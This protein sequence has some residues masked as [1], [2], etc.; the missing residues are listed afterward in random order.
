MNALQI[1]S[2][3]VVL[4]LLWTGGS[5]ADDPSADGAFAGGRWTD[6]SP[7]TSHSAATSSMSRALRKN[8]GT[9]FF[10]DRGPKLAVV[11]SADQRNGQVRVQVVRA[12]GDKSTC[13]V[14]GVVVYM[15]EASLGDLMLSETVASVAE[16]KRDGVTL[17]FPMKGEYSIY[18]YGL[19][20]HSQKRTKTSKSLKVISNKKGPLRLY[21]VKVKVKYRGMA[22]Q[23]TSS[24]DTRVCDAMWMMENSFVGCNQTMIKSTNMVVAEA[25][26]FQQSQADSLISKTK[27]QWTSGFGKEKMSI[28]EEYIIVHPPYHQQPWYPGLFLKDLIYSLHYVVHYTDYDVGQP[29]VWG[30]EVYYQYPGYPNYPVLYTPG[31]TRDCDVDYITFWYGYIDKSDVYVQT[32]KSTYLLPSLAAL[33]Y[34]GKAYVYAHGNCKGN[35]NITA[36]SNTWYFEIIHSYWR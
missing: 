35:D 8:K 30:D 36:Y 2:T 21:S 11:P 12:G 29:F 27:Q 7:L 17:R 5:C 15:R 19:C 32:F 25:S 10:K 16:A 31:G 4:L 33:D 23:S 28:S 26:Y 18:S 13:N 3:V 1:V 9:L 34:P 20:G 14:T 22:G 24:R 6:S